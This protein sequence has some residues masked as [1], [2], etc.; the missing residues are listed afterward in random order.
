MKHKIIRCPKGPARIY[1][2][3]AISYLFILIG[4]I[5]INDIFQYPEQKPVL[6]VIKT[7]LLIAT[8]FFMCR[9]LYSKR[10]D[11]MLI[12]AVALTILPFVVSLFINVT[13]LVIDDIVLYLLFFAFTYITVKMPDTQLREK[14]VKFRFI[15]PIALVIQFII[16]TV[17]SIKE[18]YDRMQQTTDTF[19][20]S[21]MNFAIIV[22][23]IIITV[24]SSILPV[25]GY[26]MLVNWLSD[27]YEK[28]TN[29]PKKKDGR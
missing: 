21:N 9:V 24:F 10:Y 16:A 11:N 29:K 12:T 23:P 19:P 25:L 20:D 13:P 7:V 3:G 27:P 6:T 2:F 5:A 4:D 17:I 26:V 22:V 15:I 14:C 18:L 1:L 8:N 28:Q